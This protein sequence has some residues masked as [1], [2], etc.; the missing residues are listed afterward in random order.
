MSRPIQ[1][2]KRELVKGTDKTAYVGRAAGMVL[3]N[4]VELIVLCRNDEDL[5]HVADTLVRNF[6]EPVKLDI[7]RNVDAVV[8]SISAL[9]YED[10]L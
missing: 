8:T 2:I 9:N 6:A 5:Q 10:E 1:R 4:G 3:R 7:K